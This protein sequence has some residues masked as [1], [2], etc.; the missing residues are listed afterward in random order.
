MTETL[1]PT[2]QAKERQSLF[3]KKSALLLLKGDSY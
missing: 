2:S 1:C 3:I